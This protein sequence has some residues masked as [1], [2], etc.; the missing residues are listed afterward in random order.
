MPWLA[1]FRRVSMSATSR[2]SPDSAARGGSQA[3][4]ADLVVAIEEIAARLA[5]AH[6]DAERR[7]LIASLRERVGHLRACLEDAGDLSALSDFLQTAGER[8]KASLARELHDQL[9]GI[10]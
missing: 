5:E 8:D 4:P 10:L 3:S 6:G 9:G 2:S 7:E 1:P